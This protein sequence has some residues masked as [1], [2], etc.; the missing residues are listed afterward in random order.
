[1]KKFLGKS[2]DSLQKLG[3]DSNPSSRLHDSFGIKTFDHS[4]LGKNC[5]LTPYAQM[6][7]ATITEHCI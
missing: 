6:Y 2:E 4:E 1:M 3:Q 7:D 5:H